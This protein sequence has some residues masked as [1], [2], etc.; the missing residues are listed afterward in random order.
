[1]FFRVGPTVV[2]VEPVWLMAKEAAMAKPWRCRLRLTA[3]SACAAQTAVGTANAVTAGSNG[4][5]LQGRSRPD[6]IAVGRRR[7]VAA[8]SYWLGAASPW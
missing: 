8:P 3:G 1:M 4:L 2:L 5:T 6:G 7:Y